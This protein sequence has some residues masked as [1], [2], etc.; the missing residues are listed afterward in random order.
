[1]PIFGIPLLG[2]SDPVFPGQSDGELRF[3]ES[4]AR[5]KANRSSYANEQADHHW[6]KIAYHV[7]EKCDQGK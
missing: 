1:M 4:A 7:L 6:K 2:F 5:K 3:Q